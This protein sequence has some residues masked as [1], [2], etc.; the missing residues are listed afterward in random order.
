MLEFVWKGHA[1]Y[2]FLEVKLRLAGNVPSSRIRQRGYRYAGCKT[3]EV[4]ATDPA[5]VLR[6]IALCYLAALG[7]SG[8]CWPIPAR[9][10]RSAPVWVVVIGPCGAPLGAKW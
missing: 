6:Q 4:D 7:S 1:N 5:V 3:A 10:K 8:T 2:P 9:K